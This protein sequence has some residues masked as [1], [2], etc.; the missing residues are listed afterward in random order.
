MIDRGQLI[1]LTERQQRIL[2]IIWH[3]SVDEPQTIQRLGEHDAYWKATEAERAVAV[4]AF[5]ADLQPMVALHLVTIDD[6]ERVAL[7]H[8][9]FGHGY[10]VSLWTQGVSPKL[11][12]Q[13]GWTGVPI[14]G[15][16]LKFVRPTEAEKRMVWDI[17][18]PSEADAVNT[19]WNEEDGSQ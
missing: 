10:A 2:T 14:P 9:G 7:T 6:Q 17:R 12:K 3:L 8:M 4:E 18:D 5:R 13:W 11:A 16:A 1:E 19:W 15:H